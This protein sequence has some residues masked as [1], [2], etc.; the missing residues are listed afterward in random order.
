MGGG[1]GS[2]HKTGPFMRTSYPLSILFGV[3]STWSLSQLATPWQAHLSIA[4][5]R[6]VRRRTTTRVTECKV[7]SR[8]LHEKSGESQG[9]CHDTT[10]DFIWRPPC[11]VVEKYHPRRKFQ[12]YSCRQKHSAENT[13]GPCKRTLVLVFDLSSLFFVDCQRHFRPLQGNRGLM[14]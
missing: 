3:M 9:G 6:R 1:G 4:R 14:L 5:G 8:Y 11:P 13:S 2:T 7:N 10:G 12:D